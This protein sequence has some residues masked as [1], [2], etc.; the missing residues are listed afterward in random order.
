VSLSEPW[1]LPQGWSW[2]TIGDLADPESGEWGEEP[3]AAD[4]DVP[5]VRSTETRSLVADVPAAEI[6]SLTTKQFEKSALQDEDILVVKSSGSAH[7][8]GR[9]SIVLDL[10]ETRAGFS[11]FMLRLRAKEDVHPRLLFGYLSSPAG[12]AL[13]LRLNRTTSRLRNLLLDRYLKVPVPSGEPGVELELLGRLD[14]V[15]QALAAARDTERLLEELR[16]GTL[17]DTVA[18]PRLTG[19]VQEP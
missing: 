4:V 5:V 19:S 17:L 14:L 18:A 11:N 2:A 13:F 1:K 16:L 10:G 15:E 12:R 8:V 3:G 7:L 6:R 9:P